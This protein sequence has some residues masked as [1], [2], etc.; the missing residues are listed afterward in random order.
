MHVRMFS[1][2]T[3]VPFVGMPFRVAREDSGCERL[4]LLLN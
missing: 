1:W 2:F 3:Q 4:M